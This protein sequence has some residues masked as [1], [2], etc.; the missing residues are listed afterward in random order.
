MDGL[1]RR[2]LRYWFAL[3]R[4][5]AIHNETLHELLSAYAVPVDIF[6]A[7]RQRLAEFGLQ[8]KTLDY[9][10]NPP[11]D[12]VDMDLK[13]YQSPAS[14]FITCTDTRYPSLLK[15]IH[16][17]PLALYLCGNP[18]ILNSLQISI[19]GS[20]RPT[21]DGRRNTRDLAG[22]L[23]RLGITVTSGLA[24]GLDSE[25]HQ[26][27]LAVEGHTIAV[28]GSGLNVIYP[29][30]NKELAHR[31]T[32]TGAIIS[33]FPPDYRP[34]PENFPRRN[35]IISG[36]STGTLVVEAAARSGTLI[37]ARLAMEQG[38]EVFAVPGAIHNPLT[39][40][41]HSLIRQGAKLVE[42][43]NDIL[44]EIGPL[45]QFSAAGGQEQYGDDKKLK[46]LDEFSKLLLDNIGSQPVSIDF[47]VA[48]TELAANLVSAK[49]LEM[50]LSGV[51]ASQ[52]GGQYIR[53][54]YLGNT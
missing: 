28:L 46:G 30:K 50:E 19:V 53:I 4:A 6:S 33:E 41:C 20:R 21:P 12:R 1:S 34:R 14:H 39:R 42:N 18:D 52:P 45:A 3:M 8:Q 47:L 44:E 48:E 22:R 15:E 49:L 27:A 13:W 23:A 17:P 24:T 9:L 2:E 25:A 11:W 32:D 54:K 43:I 36:L 10:D 26:A 16:D 35:R 40:G 38:R 31:I 5:P 51:I 29:A 37:T 7:G